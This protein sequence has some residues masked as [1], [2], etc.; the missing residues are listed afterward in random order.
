MSSVVYNTPGTSTGYILPP[1]AARKLVPFSYVGWFDGTNWHADSLNNG[2]DYSG[3]DAYTVLKN[4]INDPT[5]TS[6]FVRPPVPWTTIPLTAPLPMKSGLTLRGISPNTQFGTVGPHLER[7]VFANVALPIKV[8]NFQYL[9]LRQIY[10]W[11]PTTNF[12]LA[13]MNNTTLNLDGGGILNGGNSAWE[14]I[15][16]HGC[17]NV[18]GAISIIAINGSIGLIT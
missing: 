1:V 14:D 17:K 12:I 15:Y 8:T 11:N 3:T 2:T 6:I 4:G 18:N 5:C 16:C 13:Q 7:I 10:A 9:T